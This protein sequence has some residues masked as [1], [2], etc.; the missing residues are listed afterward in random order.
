[1][2]FYGYFKFKFYLFF[3]LVD[4]VCPHP[5]MITSYYN[6]KLEFVKNCQYIVLVGFFYHVFP[7]KLTFCSNSIYFTNIDYFILFLKAH[8]SIFLA[9]P[10]LASGAHFPS[11]LMIFKTAISFQVFIVGISVF[12]KTC[13]KLNFTAI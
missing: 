13:W 7:V 2:T 8:S 5:H 10:R 9:W 11:V 1:M 6:F 12:S 3:D 4:E